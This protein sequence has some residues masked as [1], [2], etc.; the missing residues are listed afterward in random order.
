MIGMILYA[1]LSAVGLT[2]GQLAG[3]H[4]TFESVI[5]FGCL[6]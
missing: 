5:L 2:T 4:L 6:K 1:G 3:I